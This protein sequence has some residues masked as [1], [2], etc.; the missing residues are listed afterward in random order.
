MCQQRC[1]LITAQTQA[2]FARRWENSLRPMGESSQRVAAAAGSQ[3][4]M[5]AGTLVAE[6]SRHM[7]EKDEGLWKFPHCF[8]NW[9]LRSG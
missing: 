7:T 9:G 8:S 3:Y 1:G 4:E 6:I 5:L 2:H